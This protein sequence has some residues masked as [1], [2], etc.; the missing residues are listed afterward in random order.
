MKKVLHI[1]L[2]IL[3]VGALIGLRFW[4][5]ELFYDPL[6]VFFEGA[7]LRAEQLPQLDVASL[8]F[9]TSVRFWLNSTISV[10]ILFLLFGKSGIVKVSLLVYLVVFLL[11]LVAF[12]WFLINYTSAYSLTLFY[13]RRF[14]IQP[15]LLLILIPAFYYDRIRSDK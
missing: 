3:L 4:E 11:L 7:Y 5:K 1:S 10:S 14:L 6:L 13:I 15:I 12:V 8:L 2:I 9:N